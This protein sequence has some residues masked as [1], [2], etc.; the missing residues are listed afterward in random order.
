M[1]FLKTLSKQVIIAIVLAAIA[2]FI[3]PGMMIPLAIGFAAGAVIGN[4]FPAFEGGIE[5]LI[6]KAKPDSKPKS[7]LPG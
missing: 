5:R 3:W 7:K 1:D 4:L 6:A 2:F